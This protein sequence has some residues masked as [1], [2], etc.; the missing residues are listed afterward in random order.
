[1]LG[2]RGIRFD[3]ARRVREGVEEEVR[4]D[5]GLER[6]QLGD[7]RLPLD[8]LG[9]QALGREGR[10]GARFALAGE[11]D[12][13]D[14]RGDH[15]AV[16]EDGADHPRRS[17]EA[18][19]VHVEQDP[20]DAEA[21]HDAGAGA[22]GVIRR[23][24]DSA[25]AVDA[26]VDAGEAAEEEEGVDREADALRD[27]EDPPGRRQPQGARAVQRAEDDEE[28]GEERV[29]EERVGD[30]AGMGRL[31]PAEERDDLQ[32]VEVAGMARGGSGGIGTRGHGGILAAKRRA[33]RGLRRA[34]NRGRE[35]RPAGANGDGPG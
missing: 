4:L 31:E 25:P 17:V 5:L 11:E 10:L 24:G 2:A 18:L 13:R 28:A 6:V 34:A 29:P 22:A 23:D 16:E 26:T 14:D 9:A 19:Q 12:G 21:R 32:R 35:R 8:A 3:E 1:V 33:M 20:R 15:D 27:H 30:V 7:G